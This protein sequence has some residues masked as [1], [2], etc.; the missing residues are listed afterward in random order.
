[1][2]TI[3]QS[4]QKS[5]T[6]AE[7]RDKVFKLREDN[8]TTGDNH[9]QAMLGYTDLNINRMDKWDK[10]FEVSEEA[11][12]TVNTLPQKE[13]WLLL[14]EAWC[15]DAAHSVPV[16]EKLSQAS[17]K[18]DLRIVLRDENLPLM[19][20]FLTNGGRSIPKLVRLNAETK[21]VIASWGPRPD[22]LQEI[23]LKQREDGLDR[24]EINK[25]LQ[26][27]Y[28]RDRGKTIEKELLESLAVAKS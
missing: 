27:W 19:D 6:Y 8:K 10:R 25:T 24:M 23:F 14:T 1:M 20:M 18:V 13:T 2:N 16:M 17:D 12:E 4:L 5:M 15:G 3:E 26:I 7:Y 11:I 28:A 9:S 21:E 22:E